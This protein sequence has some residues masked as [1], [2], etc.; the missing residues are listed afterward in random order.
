VLIVILLIATLLII[1]LLIATSLL[2]MHAKKRGQLL[3]SGDTQYS[4]LPDLN[5]FIKPL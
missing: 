1:T 5:G 2:Q 4:Q 3:G